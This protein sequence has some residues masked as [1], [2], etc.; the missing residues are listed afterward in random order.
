MNL[1][2][3]GV[4]IN[5]PK[6]FD[7]FA[8]QILTFKSEKYGVQGNNLQLLRSHLSNCKQLINSN[9][10]SKTYNEIIFAVPQGSVIEPILFPSYL[11][12]LQ[13]ASETLHP[14]IFADDTNLFLADRN[15]NPLFSTVNVDNRKKQTVVRL[16]YLNE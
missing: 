3:L 6:A 11:N 16:P 8:H 12:D 9:N 1:F 14:V 2:L 15:I 13:H 4:L 5:L 10:Q 7:S